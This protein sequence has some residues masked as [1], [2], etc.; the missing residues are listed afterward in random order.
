MASEPALRKQ[1]SFRGRDRHS[2][3]SSP[4]TA[5]AESLPPRKFW[6][7]VAI[8]F[9]VLAL[10]LAGLSWYATTDAFQSRVRRRVV[11]EIERVTGGKVE[12]GGFHTTPFRFRIEIRN[13]TIHGK[14]ASSEIPYAHFDRLLARVKIISVLGAE[15]GF[16]SL[17]LEHPVIHIITYPDGTTNQPAPKIQ[18]ASTETPVEQLFALSIGRLEFRQGV[19]IWN[20]KQIP[21][22]FEANDVSADMT[23]SL[24]HRRYDTN[25]LLGRAATRYK[26]YRPASWT[27]EAHF[28][29]YRDS[30]E[31]RSLKASSGRSKL[32]LDGNIENFRNP[33]LQGKYDLSIDLQEA[34][35]ISHSPALRRGTLHA[36]GEGQWSAADFK[37]D[38][39]VAVKELEFSNGNVNLHGASLDAAYAFTP[40]RLLVSKIDGRVLGGSASGDL[41][42]VNWLSEPAARSTK[43]TKEARADEQQKGAIRLRLKDLSTAVVASMFSSRS[44]SL[45][46]LNLAGSTS[47]T[48]EGRWTGSPKNIEPVFALDLTPPAR[49]NP[50][51]MPLSGRARGAYRAASGE[52]EISELSLNTRATQVR[53][54]GS[55][56]SNAALRIGITTTDLFEWKPV[57]ELLGH[58]E[59]IPVVLHGKAIFN[60]VASGKLDN[61]SLGGN[62]QAQDFDSVV[63]ATERSPK[64]FIH[65]DSLTTDV[66]L[67][68]Q[69]VSARNGT[70]HHGET[71]IRFDVTANL[72][73]GEFSPSSPFNARVTM[74][75]ADASEILAL[76]GYD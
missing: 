69:A 16:D 66:Q 70:L 63:P 44:R 5:S 52:L 22:D 27:C 38:G 17:V 67:S 59:H 3:K 50:G 74:R 58:P 71:Q 46:R 39:K 73:R 12:L 30:V 28:Y 41:D 62:L 11:D 36:T 18:R 61:P 76:A 26:D 53:A 31:I 35:A 43:A 15:V 8:V 14:E 60:G 72:D 9:S 4:M 75:N 20:E 42:V 48:V 37:T 68:R 32:I 49:L 24:L 57:L 19:A 33:R 21:L 10:I 56:A 54:D 34:G 13:L 1:Y 45:N 25:V 64:R 55:L 29:L 47:G 2:R 65:W 51:Q 6:R 23:Y 40:K 7:Y